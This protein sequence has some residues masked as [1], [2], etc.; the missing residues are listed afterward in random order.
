MKAGAAASRIT[1]DGS[2]VTYTAAPGESNRILVTTVAYGSLCGS[3]GASCLSVWD[4][5]AR[6]TA[7]SG[8][9]ELVSS[10]PIVGDT[11]HC[12]VPAAVTASLGC[13]GVLGT[14]TGGGAATG[15]WKVAAARVDRRDR[16]VLRSTVPRPGIVSVRATAR[17]RG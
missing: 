15:A 9:C 8:A 16:I 12:S 2:T 5:G 1:S 17:A 11:A 7:V 6:M 13:E 14:S 10:N 4:S 3:V